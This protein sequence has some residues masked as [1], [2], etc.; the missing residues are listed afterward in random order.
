M[1]PKS[2]VKL[3]LM[4]SIV[5]LILAIGISPLAQTV[6]TSVTT[7]TT[8]TSIQSTQNATSSDV[9]AIVANLNSTF[10]LIINNLKEKGY[11][12]TE[13]EQTVAQM[14]QAIESGNYALGRAFFIKAVN[15]VY[16]L[17]VGNITAI[18]MMEQQRLQQEILRRIAELNQS[19]SNMTFLTQ[20]VRQNL[21]QLLSQAAQEAESGNYTAAAH[22]M[23]RVMVQLRDMANALN[24]ERVMTML[25]TMAIERADKI[26]NM[27]GKAIIEKKKLEEENDIVKMALK[28]RG[29]GMIEKE[30]KNG[31]ERMNVSWMSNTSDEDILKSKLADIIIGRGKSMPEM[32]YMPAQV[33]IQVA[34]ESLS[35]SSKMEKQLQNEIQALNSTISQEKSILDTAIAATEKL[36]QG[37]TSALTT[38]NQSLSNAQQLLSQVNSMRVSPQLQNVRQLIINSLQLIIRDLEAAIKISPAIV[39]MENNILIKGIVV[40]ING[41]NLTV[42]GTISP[43]S[44]VI[45]KRGMEIHDNVILLPTNWTVILSNSTEVRGQLTLYAPVLVHGTISNMTGHIVSANKILTINSTLIEEQENETD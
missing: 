27:T 17:E 8:G 31:I 33:L 9:Q 22:L 45:E 40:S 44:L 34:Q 20:D 14:I 43:G 16:S 38:L 37:D 23:E 26:N 39:E 12:T 19:I 13:L 2:I 6:T 5:A 4:V 29:L 7:T 11:N 18:R 42:L 36:M 15:I 21:T 41:N 32:L 10:S 1:I 24:R 3:S 28:V 25:T 30:M 35:R